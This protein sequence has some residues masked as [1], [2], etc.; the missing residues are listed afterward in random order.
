MRAIK[1]VY[2]EAARLTR[3]TGVV[4][5]VDHIVPLNH[6]RVCGLHVAWNLRPMP[7]RTNG[8]KGN[9]WCEWHGELFPESVQ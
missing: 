1:R 6:P 8:A 5:D 7:A 9:G 2:I 3:V 4:H